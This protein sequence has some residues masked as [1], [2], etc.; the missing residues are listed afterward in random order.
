MTSGSGSPRPW[1]TKKIV[2]SGLG[3]QDNKPRICP[4]LD[5]GG[6]DLFP[7]FWCHAECGPHAA[8]TCSHG[9]QRGEGW[10][11]D[12]C[13]R[14]PGEDCPFLPAPAVELPIYGRPGAEVFSVGTTS[15]RRD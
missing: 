11:R 2:T 10:G 15:R 6:D 4:H 7:V 5:L 9:T 14:K 13:L 3:R 12:I 1:R 8:G